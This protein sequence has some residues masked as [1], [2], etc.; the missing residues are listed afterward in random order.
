MR[1]QNNMQ[2]TLD[3]VAKWSEA[4]VFRI[5]QENTKAMYIYGVYDRN[6]RTIQTLQYKSKN[7]LD[8][9]KITKKNSSRFIS[10]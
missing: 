8:L 7:K 10:R 3:R 4:N 5:S 2:A 6:R 1:A 9:T